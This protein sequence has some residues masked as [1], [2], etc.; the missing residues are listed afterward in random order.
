MPHYARKEF[1]RGRQKIIKECLANGLGITK[2][3]KK[4]KIVKDGKYKAHISTIQRDI[5]EIEKK[6]QNWEKIHTPHQVDIYQAKRESVITELEELIKRANKAKQYK[7]A[8]ELISKKARIQGVDKYVAP[9]PKDKD[10]I[11]EKYKHKNQK[12]INDILLSDFKDLAATLMREALNGRLDSIKKIYLY[13]A[14]EID[15]NIKKFKISRY[16]EEILLEKSAN[17]RMTKDYKKD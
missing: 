7:T 10:P 15:G 9:K 13:F 1:R 11:E 6:R 17:N 2:I 4:L 12:E 8:G 14:R 16:G 5:K 3:V